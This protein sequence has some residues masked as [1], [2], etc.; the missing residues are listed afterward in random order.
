M[1]SRPEKLLRWFIFSVLIA[2]VPL[3]VSYL[4]LRLDRQEPSLYLLTERGELLLIS[5]AI[6]SAAVGELIPAGRARAIRK[7][8]AGGSCILLIM[9]SSF[10][11]AAIQARSNADPLTVFAASVWLFA[12]SLLASL[13]TLYLAYEGE[14]P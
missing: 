8:I 4:G 2:L 14:H 5:T 1:Q 7:L 9:L 10:A 6:A 3:A 11:F 13:G 12:G